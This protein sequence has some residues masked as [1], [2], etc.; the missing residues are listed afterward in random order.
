[1][2]RPKKDVKRA[3]EVKVRCTALEKKAIQKQAENA[4]LTVA[5]YIRMSALNQKIT[6]KLTPEEID[7]YKTLSDYRHYFRLISNL[8]REHRD[9]DIREKVNEVAVL[10]D[11]H[12]KKIL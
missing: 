7:A 10:I 1:M 3:Y 2:A 11:E 4:G 8:L 9:K 12:L 5:D 6:Y